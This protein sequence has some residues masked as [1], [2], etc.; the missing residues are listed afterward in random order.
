ML[1]IEDLRRLEENKTI[2]TTKKK[3]THPCLFC[4]TVFQTNTSLKTHVTAVHVKLKPFLCQ[5]CPT[6]FGD[7]SKLYRH[8]REVHKNK[9]PFQCIIV[10]RCRGR[11]LLSSLIKKLSTTKI[12]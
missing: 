10:E 3:K 9:K 12:K 8:V 5:F 1:T 6:A 7:N 4:L 11:T 2:E